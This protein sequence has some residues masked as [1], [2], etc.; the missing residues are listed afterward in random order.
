MCRCSYYVGLSV[1]AR[2]CAVSRRW[3][4][5]IQQ[6]Y[7]PDTGAYVLRRR[8]VDIERLV[9]T[10]SELRCAL[11]Q[12]CCFLGGSMGASI[13]RIVDSQG[14]RSR[15]KGRSIHHRL[16]DSDR[17]VYVQPSLQGVESQV[18]GLRKDKWCVSPTGLAGSRFATKT[19]EYSPKGR[20]RLRCSYP[21]GRPRW[22]SGVFAQGGRW[23]SGGAPFGAA[24]DCS[25]RALQGGRDC[26][27]GL[28]RN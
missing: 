7:V 9:Y 6:A 23:R 17:F 1:L 19:R 20:S 22:S 25:V 26:S 14:G 11:R 27:L 15:C 2:L 18:A 3:N 16:G 21:S 13:V 28:E 12:S 10:E 24:E 8:N 4:Q 5:L